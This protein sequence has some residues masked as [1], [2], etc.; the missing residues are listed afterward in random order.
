MNIFA[1]IEKLENFCFREVNY[2][3]IRFEGADTTEFEDFLTRMESETEHAED[4][5]NLFTWLELIGDNQGAK[6]KFFRHEGYI[7]DTKA[8]PPRSSVMEDNKLP[9]HD[10]RLYCQRLN[11]YVVIL[12]NGGIKTKRT[13]QECPNVSA[14]FN[15]ANRIAKQINELFKQKEIKWNSEHTD[16]IFDAVL[17]I[18][19]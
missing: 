3:S 13:A 1:R 2:Y 16:I 17:T 4:V 15:Q 7:S 18:E 14:Y 19:L 8:L 6:E 9:V 10:V 5:I 11:Q 12:F